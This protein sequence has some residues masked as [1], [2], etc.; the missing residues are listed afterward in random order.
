M[1]N[2]QIAYLR[3]T[4]F[5]STLASTTIS[6]GSFG[7]SNTDFISF[8]GTFAVTQLNI[9]SGLISF[10]NNSAGVAVS[11][12]ITIPV[13]SS[14]GDPSITADGFSGTAQVNWNSTTG[15]K[16][17]TVLPGN[18]TTLSNFQN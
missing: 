17:A 13:T 15:P 11:G 9:S 7:I 16:F 5:T 2:I 1:S 12:T 14:G 6:N 10:E 18:P 4:T 3:G 8:N